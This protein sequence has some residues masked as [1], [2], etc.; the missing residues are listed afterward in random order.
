VSKPAARIG[1]MHV[2]PMVTPG[3][4]PVPHV[5]GP[6]TGPGVPTVLI[7][8]MPA[9]VLGDMCV[10][11]GPPDTIILGSSGVLIGGKPAARMGDSTVHGGTI[12]VGCPNVLIGEISGGGGG[13]VATNVQATIDAIDKVE[14]VEKSVLAE[15]KTIATQIATMKSA[16]QNGDSHCDVCEPVE[17]DPANTEPE[18]VEKIKEFYFADANGNKINEVENEQKVDLIIKSENISGQ[19]VKIDLFDHP[20]DF[21][22]QGEEIENNELTVTLSGAEHKVELG[23]KV[24]NK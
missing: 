19:E 23:V 13:A 18:I 2:C 21:T 7:G 14:G 10:C 22:F 11:T 5:G 9:A 3:T 16:A 8:G 1:D 15:V 24:N 12:T 6:I 4:P 20:G 17:N